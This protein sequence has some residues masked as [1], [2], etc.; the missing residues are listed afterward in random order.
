M[1]H[2]KWHHDA[3]ANAVLGHLAML[4]PECQYTW[5]LQWRM[6]F[7]IA[8]VS[9]D[10]GHVQ[11]NYRRSTLAAMHCRNVGVTQTSGLQHQMPAV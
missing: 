1:P 4:S 5:G 6:L 9:Y 10:D 2:H 11:A 3:C 7:K 8:D